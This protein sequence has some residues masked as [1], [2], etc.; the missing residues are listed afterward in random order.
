M[1]AW[2][3]IDAPHNIR[4]TVNSEGA[5]TTTDLVPANHLPLTLPLRYLGLSSGFVDQID[6][7]LQPQVDAGYSRYDNPLARPTSVDPGARHGPS[8]DS[9][10][11]HAQHHRRRIRESARDH[12]A[13]AVR[14]GRS[15]AAA[16]ALT[17]I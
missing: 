7:V 17:C 14:V 1:I 2:L 6:A 16:F 4:T 10:S 15:G 8:G 11:G 5:K 12:R 3:M 13:A 9:G